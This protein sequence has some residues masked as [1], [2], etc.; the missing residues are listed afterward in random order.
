MAG[1]KVQLVQ[2][3]ITR[4]A[5]IQWPTQNSN[6]KVQN[7]EERGQQL[8]KTGDMGPQMDADDADADKRKTQSVKRKAKTKKAH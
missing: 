2:P 4:M 6:L 8:Y 3:Q 5:Q 1:G 7:R